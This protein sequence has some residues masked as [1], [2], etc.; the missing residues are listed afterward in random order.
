MGIAR[1]S[2]A[3]P[4]RGDDGG[5]ASSGFCREGR[6]P[7]QRPVAAAAE[8]E[9]SLAR[10]CR[11]LSVTRRRRRLQGTQSACVNLREGEEMDSRGRAAVAKARPASD[12]GLRLSRKWNDSLT[13]GW[14]DPDRHPDRVPGVPQPSAKPSRKG[15]PQTNQVGTS[16]PETDIS[17]GFLISPQEDLCDN[18]FLNPGLTL[19]SVSAAA[20]TQNRALLVL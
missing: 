3:A 7:P 12:R 14:R 17:G 9:V 6:R 20:E 5:Q 8:G 19:A 2:A 11:R 16:C 4:R 1:S 10:R 15:A 13:S 18:P